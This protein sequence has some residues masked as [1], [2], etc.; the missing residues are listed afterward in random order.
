MFQNFGFET[1]ITCD[2]VSQKIVNRQSTP[3]AYNDFFK[4][5]VWKK[6]E[7]FLKNE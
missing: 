4:L 5:F 3:N 7:P 1:D 2:H 6:S